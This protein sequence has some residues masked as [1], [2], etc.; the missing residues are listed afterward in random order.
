MSRIQEQNTQLNNVEKFQHQRSQNQSQHTH[1]MHYFE[2]TM[3]DAKDIYTDY[4]MSILQPL[5]YEGFQSM[6]TKALDVEKKYIDASKKDPEVKNPGALVL[7]QHFILRVENWSDRTIMSETTRVRD[8]SK[9]ADIFDDLIRAVIKSHII[10]LTYNASG[11]KCKIVAE[12]FYEKTDIEK[13][14]H[15][16]Y[17]EC[18]RIF[19]DHAS[20]FWHSY[21]NSELKECQRIIYQ[22][23]KHGIKKAINISLPMKDIL[24]EYLNNDYLEE[25]VDENY[26]KLNDMLQRD[27]YGGGLDEGGRM[28][29]L[30]SESNKDVLRLDQNIN[31]LDALIYN[32]QVNDTLEGSIQVP[33]EVASVGPILVPEIEATAPGSKEGGNNDN[34]DKKDETKEEPINEGKEINFVFE[35]GAKGI[36][37]NSKTSM[38]LDALNEAK[39]NKLRTSNEKKEDDHDNAVTKDDDKPIGTGS[40]DIVRHKT[41][42]TD[43]IDNYFNDIMK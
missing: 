39:Q 23:V 26:M 22:L 41:G 42:N 27:L 43:D 14:I 11:K 32:R 16:C 5:I 38:F 25:H 30:D 7:F 12:K 31:D 13:F 9:C 36:R 2:K 3:V 37:K 1:Y 29:I 21:P 17:L 20:L 35:T 34:N 10:V 28:R 19:Y 8:N 40:I 6:Y 15:S 33:Q 24:E 18:S 4:L